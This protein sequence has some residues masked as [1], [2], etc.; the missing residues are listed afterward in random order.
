MDQAYTEFTGF[1]HICPKDYVSGKGQSFRKI[2][3]ILGNNITRLAK[4]FFVFPYSLLRYV[5]GRSDTPQSTNISLQLYGG[6]SGSLV[7]WVVA[8]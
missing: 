5:H 2:S 1:F 6:G 3:N 4:L 7:T 8:I